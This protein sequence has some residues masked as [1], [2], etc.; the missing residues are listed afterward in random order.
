MRNRQG[1]LAC[2]RHADMLE[3]KDCANSVLRGNVP[4]KAAAPSERQR[5]SALLQGGAPARLDHLLG[6]RLTCEASILSASPYAHCLGCSGLKSAR[7]G[8]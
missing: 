4:A 7:E 2:Q 1:W 8:S 5:S 6:P 3:V